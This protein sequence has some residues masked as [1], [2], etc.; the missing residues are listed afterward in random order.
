MAFRYPL[1]SSGSTHYNVDWTVGAGGSNWAEDVM[2]VQALFRIFFYD[3]NGN[4]H[5]REGMGR[6]APP[7]GYNSIAVD[8]KCGPATIAHIRWFQTLLV[9]FGRKSGPDSRFD[10]TRHVGDHMY[11]GA[12][13][14]ELYSLD[15]LN[16]FCMS[17]DVKSQ[18][19]RFQDL[20]VRESTPPALRK[21]LAKAQKVAK[22]N[23]YAPQTVPT[24]GGA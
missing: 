7:L 5:D 1:N 2:L 19:R 11:G 15:Y 12:N 22:Q 4:M 20:P 21:A 23:Q 3:Y 24:T 9:K 17:C 8:G 13:T 18:E 6:V 10:P 14:G 16:L